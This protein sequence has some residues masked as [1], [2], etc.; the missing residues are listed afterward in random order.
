MAMGEWGIRAW[1]LYMGACRKAQPVTCGR[2]TVARVEGPRKK[3]EGHGRWNI[4]RGQS[5][6]NRDQ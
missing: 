6:V 3:V 5:C 1:S 2:G 4:G